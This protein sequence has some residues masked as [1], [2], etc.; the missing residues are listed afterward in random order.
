VLILDTEEDARLLPARRKA[1]AVVAPV[2]SPDEWFAA[3]PT[4]QPSDRLSV[5]FYGLFT[6]LQGATVIGEAIAK[7]PPDSPI[8]ITMIGAGQDL[9]ETRAR[10]KTTL[11]INWREWVEPDELRTLVHDHDVC[12]GIFG[13]SDKAR[14]V[15][16]NKV[17]Q[18]AAA[19]CM[20]LTSDTPPQRR[21]MGD[22]ACYVP[23]GDANALAEALR[24]LAAN[25][26]EVRR[27]RVAAQQRAEANFRPRRVAEPL[28]AAFRAEMDRKR[29]R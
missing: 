28:D 10:A 8:E 24:S 29:H 23:P 16:P 9:A 14:R 17:F 11:T 20:I 3:P 6:P 18:G 4:R 21:S 26:D 13:T 2:G 7:L 15:T 22:A 12:L 19:G 27:L 1:R 25:L 5:V